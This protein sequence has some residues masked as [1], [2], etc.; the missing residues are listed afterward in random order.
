MGKI[1]SLENL[2]VCNVFM[3]GKVKN[4]SLEICKVWDLGSLKVLDHLE[5]LK[6]NQK[7][8]PR[9]IKKLV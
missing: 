4:G 3:F 2:E 1:I 5:F 6:I 8:H 7:Q 9:G